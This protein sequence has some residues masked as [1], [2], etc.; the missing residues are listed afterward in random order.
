LSLTGFGL[1]LLPKFRWKNNL[2][3]FIALPIIVLFMM[4]LPSQFKIGLRHIFII[5]PFLFIAAGLA[6]AVLWQKIKQTY[7]RLSLMTIG[8]FYY[9]AT[10]VA[11]YPNY[12]TYSNELAGGSTNG[13]KYLADSNLDWGQGLVELK[14]YTD[15]HGI[16]KLP[17]IYFG[18]ADPNHYGFQTLTR[19]VF[20]ESSTVSLTDGLHSWLG[21][22]TTAANYMGLHEAGYKIR[23]VGPS[24][25]IGGSILL[26]NLP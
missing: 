12:L 5:Y 21:L 3:P 10:L 24:K 25:L 9:L 26:Y 17:I 15:A 14:R 23:G 18:E 13:Y 7:W 8:A 11:F 19:G 2:G 6:I 4:S 1:V 22:S 16:K 20:F